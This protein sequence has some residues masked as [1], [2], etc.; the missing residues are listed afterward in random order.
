MHCSHSGL[1]LHPLTLW[2]AG[3]SE[4]SLLEANQSSDGGMKQSM[5][6]P[7]T[8]NDSS[9]IVHVSSILVLVWLIAVS[10]KPEKCHYRLTRACLYGRVQINLKCAPKRPHKPFSSM[11]T[12]P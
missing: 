4:A 5:E 2:K 6:R 1:T 7:G 12:K 9:S 11:C 10:P 8:L 3:S